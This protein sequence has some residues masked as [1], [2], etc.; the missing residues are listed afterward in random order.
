MVDEE[1][2]VPVVDTAE[3]PAMLAGACELDGL[4]KR[5]MLL[6]P[7]PPEPDPAAG[8]EPEPEP[9]PPAAPTMP[10]L[11]LRLSL[12]PLVTL[13]TLISLRMSVGAGLRGCE[14]RDVRLRPSAYASCSL[15]SVC[16]VP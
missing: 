16:I 8:P 15:S 9:E 6:P 1:V 14:A 4:D 3:C 5:M 2:F 11:L 12:P 10:L 13:S 7:P